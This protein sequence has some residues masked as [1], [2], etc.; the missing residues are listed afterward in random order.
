MLG[1]TERRI[2][3][4]MHP[5]RAIFPGPVQLGRKMRLW[6][7]MYFALARAPAFRYM[8]NVVRRSTSTA[9]FCPALLRTPLFLE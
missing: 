9:H 6:Y 5:C 7:N 3:V 2:Q 8:K 4:S 1:P